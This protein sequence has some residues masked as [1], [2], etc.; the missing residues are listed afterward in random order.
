MNLKEA[1]STLGLSDQATEEEV[2][3]KYKELTRKYHPDVNKD[4]DADAKFKKINEA[5]QVIK[6]PPAS[7]P[8]INFG[9]FNP[10]GGNP[11]SRQNFVPEHIALRANISFS[12]S[13]LGAKQNI[14]YHRKVKCN[15]CEGHGEVKL[16]NGCEK[17]KGN[18]KI[19]INRGNM[20]FVQTCDKCYG[21]FKV[22][23]CKECSGAGS[24]DAD[25]NITVN[26]PGG[27]ID[28]NVLRLAG[29]GHFVGNIFGSEQYSDVH[30]HINVQQDSFLRL[31]G[32]EVI[33]DLQISL[34]E[35]LQGC[36]KK[37]PTVL[38]EKEIIIK[39]LS[40]HNEYVT[41]PKVGVNKSGNQKVFL[42]VNYP[43]NID[44]LINTLQSE[45]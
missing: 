18:G 8:A 45:G 11:F 15:R 16:D 28:G 38:G 5:Y 36:K 27:V 25:V 41:I 40:K 31:D 19:A 42:H 3:K 33:C 10:F 17:C 20:V 23:H 44:N 39:P 14:N 6:N 13:I 24:L 12:E 32:T 4:P 26:I 22:E 37:V 34:L 35:A 9:G 30:L 21:R 1:Y 2:K 29:M 43:K 7:A